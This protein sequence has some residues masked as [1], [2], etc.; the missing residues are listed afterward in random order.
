[1]KEFKGDKARDTQVAVGEGIM[2]IREIF[3]QLKA[4]KYQG[5]CMLEYEINAD[6]PEPGMAKSFEYMRKVIG[7]IS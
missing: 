3:A 6:N 2:P 7:T 4:M 5:G 1:M